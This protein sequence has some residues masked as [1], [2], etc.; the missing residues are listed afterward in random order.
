MKA[1]REWSF[2]VRQH[3]VIP[4]F[5]PKLSSSG[6]GPHFLCI[7]LQ[8]SSASDI[9]IYQNQDNSFTVLQNIINGSGSRLNT[10]LVKEELNLP[11]RNTVAV[12]S[13]LKNCMSPCRVSSGKCTD[14]LVLS[15][16]V[17]VRLPTI[18]SSTIETFCQWSCV[19]PEK[20]Q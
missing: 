18:R 20:C 14:L 10:N 15:L 6:I 1:A 11:P 12:L 3:G 9:Y 2:S 19:N 8:G 4:H 13:A 17:M 5:L 16:T 7:T